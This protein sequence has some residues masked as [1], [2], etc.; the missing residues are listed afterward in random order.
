ME[1]KAYLYSDFYFDSTAEGQKI[2]TRLYEPVN[3][4]KAVL[5]IVHGMAEHTGLYSEFCE[6]L[7]ENGIVCVLD[8][9]LGH[10]KSVLKGEDYG[11]FFGDIENL[12]KDEKKLSSIII[13][14]YPDIPFFIMGHSMGSFIVREFIVKYP[15]KAKAAVIMGTSEGMSAALWNAEKIILDTIIKSKG[16]NYKSKFVSDLSLKAYKSAFPE[17][18]SGWVTSVKSEQ[19]R[20]SKDPLCG[21]PLTVGSYRSMGNLLNKIN[22][23]DWYESVPRK[24]GLL[25]IS[26]EK[27]AVGDMGKGINKIYKKLVFTC[28]RVKM[29]LY[30]ELRHALIN[31][32]NTERTFSDILFFLENE[33]ARNMVKNNT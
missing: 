11:N 12:I 31:E 20:Y 29:I 17:H 32:K 28:H 15:G 33:I 16:E 2:F 18:E 25:L 22:G 19:E 13:N 27:D 9:H 7:A 26:G 5:Q 10:G 14:K 4:V 8:D 3:K 21:F 1:N 30:P 24:M 23:K 6:F